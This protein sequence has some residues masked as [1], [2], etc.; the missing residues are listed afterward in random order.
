MVTFVFCCNNEVEFTW[1][2]LA[3]IVVVLSCKYCSCI[4]LQ[5]RKKALS[6]SILLLKSHGCAGV[7]KIDMKFSSDLVC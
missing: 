5:R 1:S 6:L 4:L 3:N 7:A 2:L